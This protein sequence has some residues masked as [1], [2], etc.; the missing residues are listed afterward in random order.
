MHLKVMAGG[1]AGGLS[2][3]SAFTWG[4][5]TN[6]LN[7]AFNRTVE[8]EQLPLDWQQLLAKLLMVTTS[9]KA[10]KWGGWWE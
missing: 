2:V 7:A 9:Q 6:T 5:T 10:K 8:V 3:S 1:P 4:K